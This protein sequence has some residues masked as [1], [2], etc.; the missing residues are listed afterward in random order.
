MNFPNPPETDVKRGY[1]KQYT[2][3]TL[4]LVDLTNNS[5]SADLE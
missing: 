5:K 1:N 3:L 2:V 4:M